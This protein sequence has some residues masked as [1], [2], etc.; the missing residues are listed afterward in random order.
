M[1]RVAEWVRK[2]TESV[3]GG[4]PFAVGDVVR[5]PDGHP[6]KIISGRYWG[7]YGVSNWWTWR[8]CTPE[9]IER[10]DRPVQSGYGWLPEVANPAAPTDSA[11]TSL[12]SGG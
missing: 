12:T 4:A 1:T 8:E 7:T 6:V 3:T 2:L 5:H 9:G 11:G 10:I